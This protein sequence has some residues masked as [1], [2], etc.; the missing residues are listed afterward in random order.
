MVNELQE[1]SDRAD[2]LDTFVRGQKFGTLPEDKRQLM[3]AQLQAMRS[4]QANLDA[5]LRME[6]IDPAAE[7]P[8]TFGMKLVG[9][10][11]NPSGDPMVTKVKS[12]MAEAADIVNE[13][14]APKDYLDNTFRGGAIRRILDAQ[15]WVV[16]ALTYKA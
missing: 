2:R 16:K 3:L 10:S 7:H 4:Y 13:L 5:R 12:L 15:M 6:G 11:F 9:H 8:P 1:L 14:E